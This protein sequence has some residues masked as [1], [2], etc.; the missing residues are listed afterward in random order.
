MDA[1]DAGVLG[2]V[3]HVDAFFIVNLRG[4]GSPF[5]DKNLPH[6]CLKVPGGAIHDFIPHMAY[7]VYLLIGGHRDIRA[8]WWKKDTD[9]ILPSDEFRAM[10]TCE[11]GTASLGFSANAEPGSFW[12]TVYTTAGMARINFFENRIII[13]QHTTGGPLQYLRNGLAEG[14]A[15]QRTAIRSL[16]RKLSGGA[17]IYEGLY[18]LVARMY[19]RIADGG[20]PPISIEQINATNRMVFEMTDQAPGEHGA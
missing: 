17:G 1:I 13:D 8:K 9:T 4:E 5:A 7:L 18:E 20:P 11:R 19:R 14:R 12:L 10:V 6:P 2:D 16:L 15:V 3:M